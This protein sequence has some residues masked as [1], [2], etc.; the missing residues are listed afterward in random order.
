MRQQRR[1][2]CGWGNSGCWRVLSGWAVHHRGTAAKAIGV[3]VLGVAPFLTGCITTDEIEA[4]AP[5]MDDLAD[6]E[7]L[8][9][10]AQDLTPQA[11]EDRMREI[12]QYYAEP[13]SFGK[14]L[15]SYETSIKSISR[16]NGYEALWRGARACAWIAESNESRG[17]RKDYAVQGMKMA[18]AAMLK[19]E[20]QGRPEPFYYYAVCLGSYCGNTREASRDTLTKMRDNM[21]IAKAIDPKFD[22]CGANR[23]LGQLYIQTDSYPLLSMGTAEQGIALLKEAVEQCPEFG[24]NHLL[25]AKALAED[26][27]TELAR[28]EI[29]KVM[30]SPRLQDHSAEHDAWLEQATTLLTDLQGK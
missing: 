4:M 5:S 28:A 12:D 2:E 17:R 1:S 21:K 29:E 16:Q 3:A 18:K 23:F 11:L 27:Q 7:R 26:G 24:E 14:V 22:Y 15:A 13:R 20:L 25:Y 6:P 9:Y 10:E 30:A 8:H 19:T